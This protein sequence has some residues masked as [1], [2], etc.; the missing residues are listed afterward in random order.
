[1]KKISL[2]IAPMLAL[3]VAGCSSPIAMQST[4]YDDMYYTSTDKTE[5]VEPETQTY[6]QAYNPNTTNNNNRQEFADG[7][8][9]NPEYSESNIA[10]GNDYYGDEYYDGRSYNAR[11]NWYRPNY[12]FVDPYWATSRSRFY[13]S[14]FYDPYFNPY[15][16]SYAA[17][18]DPFFDPFFPSPFMR[19]GFNVSLSMGYGWGGMWPNR[20]FGNA[21][22]PGGGFYNGYYN[23]FHN[24]F[25][26]RN[27]NNWYYDRVGIIGGQPRQ[28][29]YGPRGDRATVPTQRV[30][31]SEG[32]P[33]RGELS[34]G[35]EQLIVR[36]GNSGKEAIQTRPARQSRSTR[37]GQSSPVIEQQQ[38][39]NSPA[40][41]SR[42]QRSTTPVYRQNNTRSSEPAR[43][44]PP[45]QRSTPVRTS[46]PPS[47]GSN[48]RS[49][50]R[51]T[52]GGN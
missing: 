39:S 36:P 29:Q 19:S 44:S 25:Y 46:P 26:A 14:A 31:R 28:V 48:N 3:L 33:Q 23:G 9:L 20:G 1:M 41:Q 32:R 34:S 51:P 35:N 50:G 16:T 10:L 4:E 43:V 22:M 5:Y 47:S 45:A 7:E 8:I 11:D 12:S 37:Q 15:Y 49:G 6:E 42:P 2:N 18:Y 13:N 40:R 27:N 24:G 52:R 17:V 30:D 21:W 38:R